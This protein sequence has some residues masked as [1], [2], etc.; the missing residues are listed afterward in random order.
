[1]KGELS[2]EIVSISMTESSRAIALYEKNKFGK[3][4]GDI[5]EISLV[6]AL[7]LLEKGRLNVFKKDK[8]IDFNT[9][10]E[11][12]REK[13]LYGRFVVFRDLKDR[14]YVIKS[15]YKYGSDFRLYQRGESPGYT[16]SQYLVKIIQEF[17][18]LNVSDFSS[19]AR[20]AH[21]VKK[22]LYLAV[23]D[24]DWDITYYSVSWIRP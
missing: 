18:A 5:L 20:V 7:F 14:G 9:L 10:K 24:D 19:Y 17:D 3:K 8:K 16:H 13:N 22:S 12:L 1:M 6:E 2:E 21:G 4:E 11:F 15:G 23:I